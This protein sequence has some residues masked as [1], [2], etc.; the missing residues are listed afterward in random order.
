VVCRIRKLGK[1]LRLS[2]LLEVL[3]AHPNK[4]L[5]IECLPGK[6][7]RPTGSEPTAFAFGEQGSN[8]LR[9]SRARRYRWAAGR[10]GDGLGAHP[11]RYS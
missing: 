5:T 1:S 10:F 6:M 11:E 2:A 8:R 4:N 9:R 7:A 3:I